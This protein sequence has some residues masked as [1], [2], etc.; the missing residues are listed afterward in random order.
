MTAFGV[1][2]ERLLCPI[3]TCEW[4]HD[5]ETPPAQTHTFPDGQSPLHDGPPKDLHEAIADV[6]LA[7]LLHDAQQTE[8]VIRAHLETHTLEDWVRETARLRE[9]RPPSTVLEVATWG[10]DGDPYNRE[11]FSN[12]AAA[13]AYQAQLPGSELQETPVLHE[14]PTRVTVHF[15]E[16]WVLPDGVTMNPRPPRLHHAKHERWSHDL[17]PPAQQWTHPG[18]HTHIVR[19]TTEPLVCVLKTYGLDQRATWSAH[20][21]EEDRLR[22]E[23][24]R[25]D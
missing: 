1:R 4:T 13:E 23:A 21:D 2:V 20:L 10:A 17:W 19:P 22:R 14:A 24:R 8:S 16:T 12:L 15:Y 3:G 7:T 9:N 6:A 18:S 5:R 11:L 25:D